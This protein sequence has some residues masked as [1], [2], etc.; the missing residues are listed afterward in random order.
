MQVESFSFLEFCWLRQHTTS[1]SNKWTLSQFFS[2]IF[3]MRKFIS[4]SLKDLRMGRE[5]FAS[6]KEVF[7]DMDWSN[8]QG[9]EINGWMNVWRKS[10]SWLYQQK[11]QRLWPPNLT[12]RIRPPLHIPADR[13]RFSN[14]TT[15]EPMLRSKSW[16]GRLETSMRLRIVWRVCTFE[17]VELTLH[18][19]EEGF[20]EFCHHTITWSK[21]DAICQ[22]C[23]WWRRRIWIAKT[24]EK[25]KPRLRKI[26]WLN[27]LWECFLYAIESYDSRIIVGGGSVAD[28]NN[29]I[30]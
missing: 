9:S 11:H 30:C 2:P 8:R 28:G 10:V 16:G 21:E 4:N 19:I 3:W 13:S 25:L 18:R 14:K 6:W 15:G 20:V 23:W 27:Y 5:K 1:K 26:E 7:M 12:T 17:T 22:A 29:L 24:R